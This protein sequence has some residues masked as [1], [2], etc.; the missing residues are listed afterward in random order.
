MS[1]G[2]LVPY[3]GR[4]YCAKPLT[5][6]PHPLSFFILLPLIKLSICSNSD[7]LGVFWKEWDAQKSVVCQFQPASLLRV[8]IYSRFTTPRVWWGSRPCT[9]MSS[10]SPSSSPSWLLQFETLD[11]A[12][13]SK[14]PIEADLEAWHHSALIW[15]RL[16]DCFHHSV[17]NLR[18][19]FV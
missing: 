19:L 18:N 6:W 8:D 12:L 10:S 14:N 1:R 4:W 3:F 9:C 5:C 13:F 7:C 16:R 15:K 2:K 17:D 11:I